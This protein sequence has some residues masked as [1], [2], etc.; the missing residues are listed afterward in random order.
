MLY[1]TWLEHNADAGVVYAI[2]FNHAVILSN[3][4]DL[5]GARAAL[6]EAVRINPDF[7]PAYINYGHVLE[8]MGLNGDGVSQWYTVSNRLGTVNGENVT[9][10]LSALKQIGRLLE[11]SN[12]DAHAE[13]ALRLS[14]EIN[15]NQSDVIQHWVSLR[16]R[17][18]KWPV[19]KPWSTIT[20]KQL[21]DGISTLSL[22]AYTD[23]PLLQLA[24]AYIY[25]RDDVGQP[26]STYHG[27]HAKVR[28][29]AH[30][31][32]RKIGY[33]SSDLREHAVG[34]LT[35]EIYGLH[36]RE[37]VEVF[38]Y[39]CGIPSN[40]AIH[41]KVKQTSDHWCDIAAMSDDQAADKIAADGIEIL[42]DLNGYTNGARTKV[43]AMSP[44]PVNVNWLGYPGTLGS[45]YFHYIIADEFIIPPQFEKY[46]SERVMR[47]PC[48]QS[49]DRGRQ[50]APGT[51]TRA[52]HGL[53]E[54]G[55]IFCCFNGVHKIT[56][57]TWARWMTILKSVP[58]SVLWLLEGIDTTNARLKEQAQAAGVDP[59]RIV[60]AGKR[61]NPHHLARYP[62]ADLFLD[63]SPYGAHTT[64]SDALWMGVPVLTL[65]G[66]GF[67]SRV[68]GSL[69]TSAGL[70]DLI[71]TTPDEFVARA[72]ELG[73]DR[74]QRE[75][76]RARLKANRDT[77]VLFDTPLLVRSLEDVY[78][79]MWEEYVS[80][81]MPRPNLINLDIY[82]DIGIA[83]DQDDVE[84]LAVP[85]YEEKYRA[86]LAKRDVLGYLPP[87][88][89]LWP[90]SSPTVK[91]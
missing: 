42:I 27:G 53:P 35:A 77:C 41:Q 25:A 79:R 91:V 34:F 78:A 20:R 45:P 22:D 13:D 56:Q 36:D 64:C 43:F 44:A 26:K 3:M 12:F 38:T 49:N 88:P 10:K 67:A 54:E 29:A 75:S 37:K 84:L 87:D 30:P 18:C 47:I 46:Y 51:P 69:I 90:G 2:H 24:N 59:A 61:S 50:V 7:Y 16:Q 70:A 8:R 72:I 89:R 28:A 32:R 17:Q 5:E 58:G 4:G 1:K 86:E 15:A 57:F 9:Y 76:L 68:C 80:G 11:K 85:D 55:T 73:T 23:D 83:L 52:E 19:I 21:L 14:L 62:L 60:F 31:T 66:R 74:E 6:A 63:T 39:Y 65:A 33:V 82:N 48:Y 81:K 40:D 71:C